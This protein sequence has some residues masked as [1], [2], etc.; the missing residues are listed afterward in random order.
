MSAGSPEQR[1]P[2]RDSV[3]AGAHVR[4]ERLYDDYLDAVLAGGAEDPGAF[5]SRHSA[6]DHELL[7]Q[8]RAL[9]TAG[10]AAALASAADE[11]DGEP[12]LPREFG[13]YALLK[14][15]GEGVASERSF[16]E[17]KN[18]R[19]KREL[20]GRALVGGQCGQS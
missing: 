5:L 9:R 6:Q 2:F 3:E 18:A 15:L 12:N 7:E 13:E 8:L 20:H 4:R 10:A 1:T 11:D 16:V 14:K 19:W 17:T